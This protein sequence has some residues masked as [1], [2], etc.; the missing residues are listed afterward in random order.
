VRRGFAMISSD[1]TGFFWPFHKQS[2]I[3]PVLETA[4]AKSPGTS[5]CQ[6]RSDR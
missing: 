6:S 5:I 3:P 1:A 4:S 2:E